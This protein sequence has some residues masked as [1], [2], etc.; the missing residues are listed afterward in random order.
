MHL[1]HI[2]HKDEAKAIPLLHND[3]F[4]AQSAITQHIIG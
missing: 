2:I 3:F 1:A 4:G